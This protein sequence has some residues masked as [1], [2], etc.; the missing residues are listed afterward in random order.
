[1]S[2]FAH[3]LLILLINTDARWNGAI[4]GQG[5]PTNAQFA[6]T[7]SQIAQKYANQPNVIFGIMNEPH[8]GKFG[9]LILDL[10][11]LT[12]QSSPGHKR[13]GCIC[14]SSDHRDSLS[15]CNITDYP[16]TWKQLDFCWNV[17]LIR[18]GSSALDSEKF[19]WHHQE[20]NL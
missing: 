7:W 13:L 5:G 12:K 4:I 19:G 18:F 17:R 3:T 2:I 20:S 16:S 8:D 9:S 6:N 11:G 15:W 10:S 14:S 1:M